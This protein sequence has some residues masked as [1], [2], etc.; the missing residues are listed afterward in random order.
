[1]VW[2]QVGRSFGRFRF[3]GIITSQ[4]DEAFRSGNELLREREIELRKAWILITTHQIWDSNISSFFSTQTK[5]EDTLFI[6]SH[7]R[8]IF[9]ICDIYL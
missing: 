8:K 9:D 3:G 5:D 2:I 4:R 7:E 6:F 1:M